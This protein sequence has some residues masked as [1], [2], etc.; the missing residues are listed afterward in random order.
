MARLSDEKIAEIQ[1]LYAS[2][3]IYSQVAKQVGCSAA[4][5]KKY[6]SLDTKPVVAPSNIIHFSGEIKE[7][8][9]VDLTF[10]LEKSE[11]LTTLT[12][13]EK[14]ELRKLWEEI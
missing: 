11:Y 13:P 8:S 3:G 4:T 14:E 9:N 10:F 1:K 12:L 5:V 6:C 2:I 7:I